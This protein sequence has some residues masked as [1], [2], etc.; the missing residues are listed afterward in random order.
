[1]PPLIACRA[2]TECCC[3]PQSVATAAL[4][5]A[6]GFSCSCFWC[7]VGQLAL[8]V[9]GGWA[10]SHLPPALPAH[11]ACLACS[12]A[13]SFLTT[14]GNGAPLRTCIWCPPRPLHLCGEQNMPQCIAL[15]ERC[16][17]PL[18]YRSYDARP[19]PTAAQLLPIALQL[20]AAFY[21]LH[22]RYE[23]R[24]SAEFAKAAMHQQTL[25]G[26]DTTGQCM[27]W[28]AGGCP[29]ASSSCTVL[30]CSLRLQAQPVGQ[31]HPV[32]AAAL[33]PA[34]CCSVPCTGVGLPLVGTMTSLK[35]IPFADC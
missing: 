26:C 21:L 35:P 31:Q 34:A 22:R 19:S 17:A 12:C 13:R 5:L 25:R 24:A 10:S 32:F 7:S 4:L 28:E 3:R 29:V 16:T 27:R 14:L 18:T 20:S 8:F 1:M 6:V 23:W 2:A 11:P 15:L 9:R 33:N 30:A